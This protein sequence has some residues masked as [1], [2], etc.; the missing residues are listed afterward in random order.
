MVFIYSFLDVTVHLNILLASS[1]SSHEFEE[2]YRFFGYSSLSS[3][4]SVHI[5]INSLTLNNTF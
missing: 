1:L 5:D 2:S 3:P 4:C